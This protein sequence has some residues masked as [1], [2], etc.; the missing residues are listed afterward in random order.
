[1]IPNG[2]PGIETRLPLLFSAGVN[3]GR[4][5]LTQFAEVTA[6]TPARLY[7]LYPKKGVIAVGSDADFAIWDAGREVTIRNSMLHHATDHT[8]YEDMVVHGWPVT[9]ISRGE[10]VWHDGKVTIKAGTWPFHCCG[11]PVPT[12]NHLAFGAR[13]MTG[14]G[15]RLGWQGRAD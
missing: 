2:V 15:N 3:G 13:I 8:P 9:T 10:V 4:M 12:T 7:G 6:T 1:M 5:S 11:T 14:A